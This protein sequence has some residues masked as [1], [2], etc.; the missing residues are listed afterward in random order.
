VRG[1]LRWR[2]WL[3]EPEESSF[4]CALRGVLALTPLI[5]VT[6]G[7]ELPE[8][9][10]AMCRGLTWAGWEEAITAALCY[11]VPRWE[12]EVLS[13]KEQAVCLLRSC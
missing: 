7:C 1:H 8:P 13:S 9:Q 2:G 5:L 3:L 12:L 4:G 11:Y 6:R 10:P